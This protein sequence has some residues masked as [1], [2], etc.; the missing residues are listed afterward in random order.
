MQKR[1]P[2]Q[3]IQQSCSREVNQHCSFMEHFV[4][5]PLRT[6]QEKFLLEGTNGSCRRVFVLIPSSPRRHPRL[7]GR[8]FCVDCKIRR[9]ADGLATWMD[10]M[11]ASRCSSLAEHCTSAGSSAMD[12][13]MEINKHLQWM[14]C[15]RLGITPMGRAGAILREGAY[16]QASSAR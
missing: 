14:W 16:A 10:L 1:L 15:A 7:S 4:V 12:P 2:R 13:S 9:M 6:Q 5:F 3:S 8:D 11:L